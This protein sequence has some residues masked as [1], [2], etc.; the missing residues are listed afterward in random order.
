MS[1][2]YALG[3]GFPLVDGAL[4]GIKAAVLVI[5]VEALIRIGKRALK[6]WLLVAVGLSLHRHF[7]SGVPFPLIVIAAALIGFFVARASPEQLGL[8][9]KSESQR[10]RPDR[11]RQVALATVVGLV[12]W[13]APVAIA[14]LMLGPGH[15]LV[16]HRPVLL[17]ARSGELRRRLCAAGLYGAGGGRDPSLD[18]RAGNG[19]RARAAE[20]TPGPLILVTQ[21]VGFLAASAKPR[22]SR[23]SWPACSAPR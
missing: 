9:P 10:L 6:T 19:R 7:L 3:R 2:L 17:Q 4:F 21:F 1:L 20:T 13:W 5:V 16:Q 14:A 15:V 11:W 12:A 23:R 22:R 18:D 8:K